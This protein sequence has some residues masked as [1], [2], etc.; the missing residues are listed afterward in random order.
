MLD[1]LLD[2]SLGLL[3]RLDRVC[4]SVFQSHRDKN[5]VYMECKL[6]RY[7]PY[8]PHSLGERLAGNLVEWRG[9]SSEKPKVAGLE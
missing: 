9:S 7:L 2:H 1:K 3:N 6:R 8:L 5:Q 4:S